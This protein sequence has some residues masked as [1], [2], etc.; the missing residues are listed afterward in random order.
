MSNE[1]RVATVIP[2]ASAALLL[3]NVVSVTTY[4]ESDVYIMPPS[5]AA[6]LL[7]KVLLMILNEE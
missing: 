6:L 4:D 2:P 3:A 5:L 1:D 7:V